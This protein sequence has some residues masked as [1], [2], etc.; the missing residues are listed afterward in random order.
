MP[1]A[2]SQLARYVRPPSTEQA[3]G[4]EPRGDD[5]AQPI[6]EGEVLADMDREIEAAIERAFMRLDA[7][8][9]GERTASPSP[10]EPSPP[11]PD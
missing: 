4:A 6:T 5:V 10:A 7:L 8:A 11:R 9:S 1:V 3:G 2:P